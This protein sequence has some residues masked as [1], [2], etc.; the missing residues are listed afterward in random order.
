MGGDCGDIPSVKLVSLELS[1]QLKRKVVSSDLVDAVT[2]P[3]APVHQVLEHSD[4]ERM[5]EV[6][7]EKI[8][9]YNK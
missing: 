5:L 6:S 3:L 7:G 8:M 9:K 1:F 4:A 2:L